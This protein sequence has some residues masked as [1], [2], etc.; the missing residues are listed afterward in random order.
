METGTLLS[1]VRRYCFSENRS[2]PLKDDEIEEA[3]QLVKSGKL[4]FCSDVYHVMSYRDA[5]GDED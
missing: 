2:Y 1:R 4:F 3:N 5:Y